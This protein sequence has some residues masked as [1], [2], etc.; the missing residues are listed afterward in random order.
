VS[1]LVSPKEVDQEAVK[2]VEGMDVVTLPAVGLTRGH[3]WAFIRGFFRSYRAAQK[4][5]ESDLPQAALAMGGFTSAAPVLAAKRLGARTFLHESNTIPGRANR[6]LSWVVDRGF[7]GFPSS[8]ARLQRCRVAVTGTPVRSQFRPADSGLCREALGLDAKRPVVLV[9][10]GSQGA[11][12][13]N[14]MVIQALPFVVSSG[15]DWQWVH[16]TGPADLARVREAYAAAS[17]RAVVHPFFAAMEVVLG[18]ATAAISRAGASSLAEI[19]AMRLPTVL[20][21]Y[22][23]AV[24]DHQFYNALAFEQS[25]AAR[26]LP[27]RQATPEALTRLLSDLVQNAG[28][29]QR[30]Q[31]SLA[32]WHWPMAAEKIAESMLEVVGIKVPVQ[33]T[34][35][36]KG[37]DS[38]L[39]S[40]DLRAPKGGVNPEPP[41]LRQ[42][43]IPSTLAVWE[44]FPK[45]A[46]NQ[47]SSA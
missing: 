25:N 9:M 10:G 33:A 31:E 35:S 20:V 37:S 4:Q 40:P 15:K 8:A 19:A 21:P 11:S 45:A 28:E 24:D 30:I 41:K 42:W 13:I 34:P 1:L 5:F 36:A 3:L 7:V 23:A 38:S 12:G 46:P 32:Q 47:R 14:Q 29:R 16:L 17:V 22:P 27:Q 26:L 18:A 39:C 43:A 6:W 2:F 44:T